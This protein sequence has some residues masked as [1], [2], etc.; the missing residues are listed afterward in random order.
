[1]SETDDATWTIGPHDIRYE[2]ETGFIVFQT[3]GVVDSQHSKEI[4]EFFSLCAQRSGVPPFVL[5]DCRDATTV[6]AESRSIFSASEIMREGCHCSMFGA[7]FA[8]RT[9]IT[10]FTKALTLTGSDFITNSVADEPTAREWLADKRR[11]Y[12]ARNAK[13]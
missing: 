3:R 13:T 11:E 12:L 7:S 5:V 9:V 6:T 4:L 1:M 8:F 10:L 2:A